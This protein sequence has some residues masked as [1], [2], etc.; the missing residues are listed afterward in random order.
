MANEVHEM[1]TAWTPMDEEAAQIIFEDGLF[2]FEKHHRFLPI[3]MEDGSDDI[4]FLESI[5]DEHLSFVLLNPFSVMPT[6]AP[7]LSAE[8]YRKL[9][10][11]IDE[12]LS[13]YVI[14]VVG[15]T[16]QQSTIN[17]KCPIV[18]NVETRK[19]VQV[20]LQTEE[21]NLRHALKDLATGEGL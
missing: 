10:T 15:E 16:P 8:D 13:F 2:G 11:Q 18:V 5:E 3:A 17:L 6:Y 14:C 20:I 9:D 1:E 19:A 4:L 7:Q 21:Y 12:L